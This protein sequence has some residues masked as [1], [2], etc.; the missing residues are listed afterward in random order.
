M[1][2]TGNIDM[3]NRE[4]ARKEQTDYLRSLWAWMV[5]RPEYAGKSSNQD[6]T[7]KI[8]LN[9]H[10]RSAVEHIT[11]IIMPL[12]ALLIALGIWNTRRH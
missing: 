7:V 8:D 4:N 6:L 3:L 10:T 11:L 5:H 2:V 12:L 9:R 1:I